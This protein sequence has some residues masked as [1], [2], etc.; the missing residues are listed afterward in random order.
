VPVADSFAAGRPDYL[1][2]PPDDR[3]K[4]AYFGKPRRWAFAWLLIAAIGVLYGYIHVAEH[5]WLVAPLM[6]LLLMVMVPPVAVNF[7]L[8]VGRSRLSRV[9][10]EATVASFLAGGETVDVFL[11]SCGESLA[12]L[13]NTFR[14]VSK[15]AWN[16]TIT[17]YA[18]DDSARP[19][20]R[21]LAAK[22]GFRYVVRPHPGELK[23]AGN[24][25]YALAVS[26][27][28]FIAVID[29]DFAVRPDFLAETMP[30]FS[31]PDVGIV[32]TAQCFDVTDPALSYIQRY[33]GTLQEI[34]FRFIQPARDRH[35]AAICAG[36]NLVYRR[37]AIVAAG[38][39]ARVPIGEDVHSGVKLWRA[40]YE[41]RYVQLCLAKGVAPTDF[42]ALANQQA[43]WCRSS[44]LLM[45]E[46]NFRAAP[47]T[48]KQRAAFWAAFLYYMSSAALL[49][50]GPFP[51]LAMIWFFP[52]LVYPHNYW[53]IVPAL[54]ATLFVFPMLSRGWRPTIYRLCVINACCH[55][56]AIWYAIKGRVADWIPTGASASGGPVPAAVNRILCTW[57]VVVE[58]LFWS[59]LAL[60]V[61][62]AGWHR[63][64]VT[65]MLGCVQL[66]M[67]APLI[68]RSKGV[69]R[70]ALPRGDGVR[71]MTLT[72]ADSH[73]SE[74]AIR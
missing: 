26:Q 48:P 14:H 3:E 63:F 69:W 39:F 43:R 54:A 33:A 12:L 50:T 46:E 11:P 66:Y 10:H 24:L 42:A 25:L 45:I 60:R 5:A 61:H 70:R 65:E 41:T 44:M 21:L 23:K 68:T 71:V 27:G 34:F 7:W 64:W 16:G 18:L 74:G 40:G 13:D 28:Q 20:V 55:L 35:R 32:Q 53:P 6:W 29:A 72:V 37:A 9:Q 67:L 57:I 36:T 2:Q 1:P 47:F 59:G 17:V 19:E 31:D 38:G 15:L 56:Y 58:A 52:N 4:Y 62:Q 22:Y 73:S 51:I 30:Y 49:V 8:R